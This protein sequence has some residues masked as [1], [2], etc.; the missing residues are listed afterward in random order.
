M[1][2][3]KTLESSHNVTSSQELEFGAMPCD[4]QD[5]RTPS[6]CGQEAAPVNHSVAQEREK[7]LTMKDTSGL[8][9]TALSASAALQS[10]LENRLRQ[11]LASLGSTLYKLTWKKRYTPSGRSIPALR[12]SVLRTSDNEF[13]GW[14][15]PA[16]RDFR[17]IGD[18]SKSQFRKDGKERKD[19]LPRIVEMTRNSDARLTDSGEMLIGCTVEME[20][21]APLNPEHS[22][23]LMGLPPEWCDCAVMAMQSM[24]SK[25]KRS[26]KLISK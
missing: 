20:D 3:Q 1:Y 9:S 6:Q 11:N 24:P 21:F 8:N 17:D 12:G 23:W 14:A 13:T 18:L 5:G 10:A 4:K 25:R 16:A 15:T 2:G 26:S 7:G 22:R 19:T